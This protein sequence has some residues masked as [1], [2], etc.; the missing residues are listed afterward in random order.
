MLQV[1]RQCATPVWS[2]VASS[3]QQRLVYA[4]VLSNVMHGHLSKWP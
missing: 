4:Y 1:A 3:R 2:D